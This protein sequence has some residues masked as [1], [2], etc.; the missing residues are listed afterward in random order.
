MFIAN[1]IIISTAIVPEDCGLLR[2]ITFVII[3]STVTVPED[4]GSKDCEMSSNTDSFEMPPDT[5]TLDER[6]RLRLLEAINMCETMRQLLFTSVIDQVVSPFRSKDVSICP[7]FTPTDGQ[8]SLYYKKELGKLKN[9]LKTVKMI[10]LPLCDGSHFNG[11]IIDRNMKKFVHI[12]SMYPP[13]SGRRSVGSYLLDTFFPGVNEVQF[14]SFYD[15]RYQS[16]GHTCGAWLVLGMAGYIVGNKTATSAYSREMAFSLLMVLI[17]NIDDN[18]KLKK[19][20]DIFG[21]KEDNAMNDKN[22]DHNDGNDD[23]EDHNN[24]D[25][26][27]VDRFS[28]SE[29][30][31]TSVTEKRKLKEIE[32]TDDDDYDKFVASMIRETKRQTKK[33]AFDDSMDNGNDDE[34]KDYIF[35][36][37]DVST[38]IKKMKKKGH[39]TSINAFR[40]SRFRSRSRSHSSSDSSSDSTSRLTSRSSSRSRSRSNSHSVDVSKSSNLSANLCEIPHLFTSFT[41]DTHKIYENNNSADDF[42]PTMKKTPSYFPPTPGHIIQHFLSTNDVIDL[43]RNG[44]EEIVSAIPPGRKEN[45]CYLI[46]DTNNKLRR[47][48]GKK[49]IYFDDCA[50]WDTKKGKNTKHNYFYDNDNNLKHVWLKDGL[51][52]KEK[53]LDKKKVYEPLHPQPSNVI[54]FHR[55][56]TVLKRCPT[57]RRRITWI[58]DD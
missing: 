7:T 52:A 47:S 9:K 49:S 11:Y 58:E 37:S 45:I 21:G 22:N 54:V 5:T 36:P 3:I 17:E 19:A 35:N 2:F 4:C 30:E 8:N 23:A 57:Y 6:T 29:D 44:S 51:Y 28:S 27:E 48:E 15:K 53:Q 34:D 55:Y 38:P 25:D 32:D 40:R 39:D 24:D 46:S 13:K 43:L 42:I 12:D 20:I 56:Y 10:V 41:D 1:I 33:Y 16:D 31:D 50:V 14:M 18:E 26:D